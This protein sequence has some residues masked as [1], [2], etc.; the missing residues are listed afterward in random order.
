MSFLD[1]RTHEAP[2]GF[3]KSVRRREDARL[4]AGEGRFTDDV[5]V[6]G[7]L[8]AYVVRSPHAHARIV[9]IDVGGAL[10]RPGVITVLTGGDAEA[11]GLR[12]IP[13]RPVSVNPHE[14]P[15]RSRDGS[16]IFIAPHPVLATDTV[17]FVGEGVALVV[18]ETRAAA[19]DAAEGVAVQYAAL[20]AVAEARDALA[21]DAPLVWNDQGT[22]V[23][24][25]SHAGDAAATDA[26]FARSTH[27]V[28][29]DTWVPRVTGVPMEPRAAIGAYDGATGRYT[30]YAGS[31]GV[32]RQK[33][34]LA[35]ALGVPE[36]DVCVVSE[37]VG[38]NFGTRNS[39]YPEFVLVAWASKRWAGRSSGRAAGA[40][41]S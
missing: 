11:D 39:V 17:R 36:T 27:V 7:Q 30:V 28:R 8:H 15:L 32:V 21:A 24:V 23:C 3:G 2:Q 41:R 25:D 12:P 19:E 1:A 38:G 13:H 40:S 34:D 5:N 14:V 18:A 29:L 22:N 33:T 35:G 6:P 20:P 4:V 37:E 16:E 9:R 26:A 31:G 10:A